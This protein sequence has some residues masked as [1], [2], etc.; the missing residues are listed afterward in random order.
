MGVPDVHS[1]LRR[2]KLSAN[3]VLMAAFSQPVPVPG[4]MEGA[5]I[6]GCEVLSWAANNTAKLGGAGAGTGTSTGGGGALECWT[7]ISTQAYGRQNKVPQVGRGSWVPQCVG[8]HAAATK[9]APRWQCSTHAP[10]AA[11]CLL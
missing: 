7:L 10:A 2:L 5:F 1:Q 8:G 3:W 11:T 9:Q 6:R 4:G